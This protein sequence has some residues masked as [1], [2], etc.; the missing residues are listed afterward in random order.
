MTSKLLAAAIGAALVLPMHAQAQQSRPQADPADPGAAVPPIVYRSVIAAPAPAPQSDQGTPDK[1]WR[2][3]ND[4]L[5]SPA[6]STPATP[7]K[8]SRPAPV[9]HGKHH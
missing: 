6:P 9:D 7:E 4:A 8:P 2:A 5:A 3:A 1:A